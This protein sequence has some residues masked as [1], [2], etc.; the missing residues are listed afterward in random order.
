MIDLATLESV[1]DL[2]SEHAKLAA[3]SSAEIRKLLKR[4]AEIAKP[5]EGCPKVMMAL[6]RL[7][8]QPWVE[9]DLRIELSGDDASTTMNVMCDYGVGIRERLLPL[10]K[11]AVPIDEFE[12]A[13]ELAPKLVL[14]LRITDEDGKLILTPLAT[15]E[16]RVNS[17]APPELD[18][19]SAS[20]GD[21]DRPTAPPPADELQIVDEAMPDDLMPDN[22]DR[23]GESGKHAKI[24]AN[25]HE[26]RMRS[27]PVPSANAPVDVDELSHD[28]ISNVHTRPTVRRMV[29]VDAAAIAA[30]KRRD[31]RREEE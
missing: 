12:R 21:G 25:E 29:A 11:F 10:T 17:I 5:G 30:V 2:T 28:R 27:G 8:G 1:S 18:V 9:G 13:L 16:A 7:V 31:P 23:M 19:E 3:S 26:G 4:V 6:A 14:P 24:D 15:P 22:V 20:L